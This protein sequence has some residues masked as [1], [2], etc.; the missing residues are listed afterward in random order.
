[1]HAAV[2]VFSIVWLAKQEQD[3]FLRTVSETLFKDI[4]LFIICEVVSKNEQT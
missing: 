3:L 4:N 1:M 2:F